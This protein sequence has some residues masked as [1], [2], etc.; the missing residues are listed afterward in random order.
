MAHSGLA[1]LAK[2]DDGQFGGA[3]KANVF[4]IQG[5]ATATALGYFFVCWCY[6]T[7]ILG[8]FV[9][10]SYLGRFK[11]IFIGTM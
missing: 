5:Q 2:Y 11:T 3:E 9:A 1:H 10:D 6:L 7:P 4:T 8:A